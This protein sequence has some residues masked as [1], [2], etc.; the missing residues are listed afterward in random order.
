MATQ[1]RISVASVV[2]VIGAVVAVGL[3]GSHFSAMNREWYEHLVKPSYQPPGWVFG[4]VWTT[5]FILGAISA[6]L[7]WNTRPQTGLTY[8]VM[9]LFVVNG[10]LNVV[11]SALFFGNRLIY[12]AV[13]EAGVLC[14]SVAAIIVLAWPISRAGSLL[15]IPYALWTAFATYLTSTIYRLN[16]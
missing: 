5:L 4:A 1:L 10:I 16:G 6:I 12:P 2:V 8:L 11:W 3:I 9:S 14:V 13:F 7:I 15:L